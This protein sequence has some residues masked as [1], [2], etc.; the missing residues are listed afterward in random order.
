MAGAWCDY[1]EAHARRIYHGLIQRD[2]STAHRLGKKIAA[3]KLTSRFTARDVY[4]KGWTGLSDAEVIEAGAAILN[5]LGWIKTTRIAAA[6]GGPRTLEY[7]ISP[8]IGTKEG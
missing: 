1:L 6:N 3:G 8:K 2:V 4:R 5:E 7:Q